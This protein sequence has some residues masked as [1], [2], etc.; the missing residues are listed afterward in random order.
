[1]QYSVFQ[2]LNKHP[3]EI[4]EWPPSP[5]LTLATLPLF[6]I[7]YSEAHKYFFQ[8]LEKKWNQAVQ[9][10][11]R[12]GETAEDVA[13][14]AEAR[15]ERHELEVGIELGPIEDDGTDEED[16]DIPD[17]L[18]QQQGNAQQQAD[19][20]NMIR[21]RVNLVNAEEAA[22]LA[23]ELGMNNP[24]DNVQPQQNAPPDAVEQHVNAIEGR[25]N[26]VTDG[27]A[28]T[29]MGALFFPAISW[30]MGSLIKISLPKTW[31]KEPHVLRSWRS[32]EKLSWSKGFL[33]TQ[34][35]R[36]IAGGCL[37]IVLKDAAVLYYKW[38]RA[39]DMRKRRIMNYR[40]RND[41]RVAE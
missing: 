14:A 32:A 24:Q 30:A 20:L 21:E 37:F 10:Q 3:Q 33:Q 36:S 23:E 8:D 4:M 1:M 31:V 38:K 17:V 6:R 5:G 12:E 11:P 35:G 9:R 41:A 18:D 22:E 40:E 29:V 26:L 15:E 19:L 16:A 7:G 27:L 2:V 13:R 34:F 28:T 25:L 39:K